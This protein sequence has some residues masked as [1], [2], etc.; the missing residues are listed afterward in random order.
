MDSSFKDTLN[1]TEPQ[2]FSS[3]FFFIIVVFFF[4]TKNKNHFLI[5]FG[6]HGMNELALFLIVLVCIF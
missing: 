6:N 1:M 3:T 5:D 4:S 2:K